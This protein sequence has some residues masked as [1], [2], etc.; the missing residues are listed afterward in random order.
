[1][2]EGNITGQVYKKF[3]ENRLVPFIER[4]DDEKTY[5]FQDDNVPVHRSNSVLIWKI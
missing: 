5:V 1:M 3:L 4:L 2:L